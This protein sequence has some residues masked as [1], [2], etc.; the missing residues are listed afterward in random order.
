MEIQIL[1]SIITRC[2]VV[3]ELTLRSFHARVLISCK[4]L[5]VLYLSESIEILGYRYQDFAP[6][7]KAEYFDPDQ[8]ANL[9]KMA[10]A[11]CIVLQ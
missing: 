8:W 7:F 10:G 2:M 1:F 5:W 9:F 3:V 6:M 11:K 4:V